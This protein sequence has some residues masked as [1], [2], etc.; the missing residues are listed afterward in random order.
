MIETFKYKNSS[1]SYIVKIIGYRMKDTKKM[2]KF[3]EGLKKGKMNATTIFTDWL[4]NFGINIDR[5]NENSIREEFLQNPNLMIGNNDQIEKIGTVIGH[6]LKNQDSLYHV[7]VI[8]TKGSGKT[9]LLNAILKLVGDMDLTLIDKGKGIFLSI[10]TIW[11]IMESIE[12]FLSDLFHR[13]PVI[14]VIDS[15]EGNSKI[16]PF[17]EDLKKNFKKGVLFTSWTPEW[18]QF[19]RK[20]IEKIFP[21]STPVIIKPLRLD[22]TSTE[23]IDFM[24]RIFKIIFKDSN[25]R[26]DYQV[27]FYDDGSYSVLYDASQGIPS[28]ALALLRETLNEAFKQKISDIYKGLV[29]DAAI[30]LDLLYSS[31]ALVGLTHQRMN[32]LKQILLSEDEKGIRPMDLKEKLGLS[33]ATISYHLSK[34]KERDLLNTKKSGKYIY[35]RIK[36]GLIP[37]IQLKILEEDFLEKG[38][39]KKKR[40]IK[41]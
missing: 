32:I 17:L 6:Y 38:E 12:S 4:D 39:K 5:F 40:E 36:N 29:V 34:L 20:D 10:Y 11:K 3:M 21:N 24:D 16:V 33:K 35:F 37:I 26:V 14:I 28:T 8:G 23:F 31:N 41:K 1:N 7:P 13:K 30:E 2:E 18:W 19:L 15:C 9:I 22:K 25:A 27:K